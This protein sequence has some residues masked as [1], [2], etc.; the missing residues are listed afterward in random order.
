VL[1]KRGRGKII[2]SSAGSIGVCSPGIKL[3][4]HGATKRANGVKEKGG[5]GQEEHKGEHSWRRVVKR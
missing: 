2:A 3:V 4:T 1:I 5:G